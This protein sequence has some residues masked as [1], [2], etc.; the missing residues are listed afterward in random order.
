[1]SIMIFDEDGVEQQAQTACAVC[2]GQKGFGFLADGVFYHLFCYAKTKLFH[3]EV[4]ELTLDLN[5]IDYDDEK[6][7]AA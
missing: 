2:G 7:V 3:D 1:M 4:P 5:L 6:E